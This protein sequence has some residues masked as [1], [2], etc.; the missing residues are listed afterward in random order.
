MSEVETPV[1]Y[2]LE[3]LKE[4]ATQLGI[5]FHP[6]IGLE[7]LKEKVNAVLEADEPE[8]EAGEPTPFQKAAK[9][10]RIRVTCMNP[11]KR[12][13]KGDIFTCGNRV[14][15]SFKKYVPFDVPWHVP[16]IMYNMIKNK[17]T[18]IHVTEKHER[19]IPVVRLKEINAY[20]VEV[21]PDLTQEELDEVVRRN[22]LAEGKAE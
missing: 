15:G 4:R 2:E 1:Q 16:E 6:A 22:A 18:I 9:L 7:K 12:M 14:A 20:A 3:V 17:K 5:S 8:A 10:K 11:K 13:L 19:G 21:L